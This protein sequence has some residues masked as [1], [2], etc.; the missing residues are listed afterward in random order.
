[1]L[2]H[3]LR[4]GTLNFPAASKSCAALQYSN[5]RQRRAYKK[6]IENPARGAAFQTSSSAVV[7]LFAFMSGGRA[8]TFAQ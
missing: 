5:L 8:M 3:L 7:Y 2:I 4:R 1:M 6:K